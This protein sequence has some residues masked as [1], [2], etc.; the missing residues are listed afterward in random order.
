MCC[1]HR[2]P[3]ESAARAIIN[4]VRILTVLGLVAG[5][6]GGMVER[7][8]GVVHAHEEVTRDCSAVVS[9]RRELRVRL[10]P[11]KG[12][13]ATLR[14]AAQQEIVELWRPYGV[15]IVWEKAWIEGDPITKPELFVF[16]VERE[17]DK[18]RDGATPV[19]WIQFLDGAPGQLV[20]V[21]VPAARRLMDPTP[22]HN[23]Q[24]IR[25]AP[26]SVQERLLGR[27]IGRALAHEIGHYVLA[28][29]RH[30]DIGLMKPVISPADFVKEGRKH[31]TLVQDDVRALRTGRLA[32][33]QQ[34]TASR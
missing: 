16:F 12:V 19:A 30:A 9:E 25:L 28:S 32:S 3:L 2:R 7:F 23:D 11:A 5:V 34:L 22:W 15:D 4:S 6:F 20:N 1:T 33:C 17:L 21:S 8:G 24:P 27:M 18:Q 29:S 31:L 13:D 14:E 26:T 10:V